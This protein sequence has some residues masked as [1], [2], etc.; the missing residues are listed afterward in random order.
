MKTGIIVG[1][2]SLTFCAWADNF[3]TCA[4]NGAIVACGLVNVGTGTAG[5]NSAYQ[6]SLADVGTGF[7]D[8]YMTGINAKLANT[9]GTFQAYVPGAPTNAVAYAG[10]EPYMY[11]TV[12]PYGA[13]LAPGGDPYALVLVADSGFGNFVNDKWYQDGISLASTVH[14]V[15]GNGWTAAEAGITNSDWLTCCGDLPTLG[16]LLSVV[17]PAAG[18]EPAM[19]WGDTSVYKARV[20]AGNWGGSGGPYTA[21]VGNM[22]LVSTPEPGSVFLL[23][24]AVSGCAVTW[25]RKVLRK[26]RS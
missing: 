18:A 12:N 5:G 26:E 14:I 10:L 19:T 4:I 3:Q 2:L 13:N 22:D 7:A 15:L 16:N 1:M 9:T 20:A 23:I 6:L 21:Y 8:L 11:F 24:T 25:R 17:I